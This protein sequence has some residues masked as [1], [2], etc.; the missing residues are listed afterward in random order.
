MKNILILFAHPSP[1]R[2][3]VNLPLFQACEDTPGITCVD[4]YAEYPTF[5]IDISRE[6]QRLVN[7]DVVVFMFPLYWYST[8]SLL[9][10]WQDL[11]LEHDFAYGSKG[12]ALQDKLFFCALT[13]GG[14][15]KGYQHE[16]YNHFTIRELLSPMEQMANITRMR[17]LPPYA[18]FGARTAV[19]EQ[20]L[21]QHISGFIQ[22]LDDFKAG[23]IDHISTADFITLNEFVR[24]QEADI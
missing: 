2:S 12:K 5:N 24:S 15:E 19:E 21:D 11:V 13:A 23:E 4:L 8:P 17:Y 14:A 18:L 1:H 22:L 9:K 20:R 16:G 7:H 3:E 6:Q 10:E